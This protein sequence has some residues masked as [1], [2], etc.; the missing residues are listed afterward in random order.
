MLYAEQPPLPSI[1]LSRLGV[2]T[3]WQ[4]RGLGTSLMMHAMGLAAEVAPAL[5]VAL[6]VARAEG[7]P[8][9]AY[10]IRFGFQPFR[11]QP[12]W[13]YLRLRDVEETLSS[14]DPRPRGASRSG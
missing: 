3:H 5:D 11:S 2:D 8:A 13:F 6:L 12:G 9:M 14:A 10:C 1:L 7:D 4:H